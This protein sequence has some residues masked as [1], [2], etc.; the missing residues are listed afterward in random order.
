MPPSARADPRRLGGVGHEGL[1]DRVAA[2]VVEETGKLQLPVGS[3]LARQVG[4]LQRV[5][6]LGDGLPAVAP[7]R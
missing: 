3:A 5:L 2:H 7:R 6:E 1:V 4:A